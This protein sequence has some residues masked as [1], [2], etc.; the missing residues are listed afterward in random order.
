MAT[1]TNYGWDTPDDT[2][3]VKD[4]A[5]A[6]RDLGQDVDT[7]LFGITG[8]KNVGLVH[9]GTTT[10]S[11][12]STVNVNDV[13]SAA[14]PAYR[15]KIALTTAASPTI[16]FR[17]AG[18]DDTSANYHYTHMFTDSGSNIGVVTVG[19]AVTNILTRAGNYDFVCQNPFLAQVTQAYG[20]YIQAYG[21]INSAGTFGANFNATTSFT[22]FSVLGT[23]LTGTV[24]VYGIKE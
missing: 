15:I 9:I 11:A 10:F 7:S 5:L 16:R 1:T 24:A 3:L 12:A 23:G 22:G 6:I 21:S 19:N 20:T 2:D 8:G 13:F 17:V 18:A 14:Y 4:G